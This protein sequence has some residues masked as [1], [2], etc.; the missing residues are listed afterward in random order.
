[1][2]I[3]NNIEIGHELQK[4]RLLNQFSYNIINA[5]EEKIAT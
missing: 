4:Y 3:D 1:M 2:I 5:L